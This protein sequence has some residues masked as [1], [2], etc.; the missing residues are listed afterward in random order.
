MQALIRSLTQLFWAG[1]F[2][3]VDGSMPDYEWATVQSGVLNSTEHQKINYDAALQAIILLANDAPVA[4]GGVAPAT[5]AAKVL[6]LKKGGKIAVV[7]PQ[8]NGRSSLF[9]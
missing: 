4:A 3:P 1:L 8:A 5:S 7:G 9:R 6:P 2:D